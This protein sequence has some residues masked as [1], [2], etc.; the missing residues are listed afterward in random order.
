MSGTGVLT[1]FFDS[2]TDADADADTE[3]DL[4]ERYAENR[5]RAR[6]SPLRHQSGLFD[7]PGEFATALAL[8]ENVR[9][10]KVA[11]FMSHFGKNA[12]KGFVFGGEKSLFPDFVDKSAVFEKSERFTLYPAQVKSLVEFF[13]STGLLN[14]YESA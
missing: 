8:I 4:S 3:T 7:L 1:L 2:D 9:L 5:Y 13:S 12:G 10:A 14:Q 11:T 6:G